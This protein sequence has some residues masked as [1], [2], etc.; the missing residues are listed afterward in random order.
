MTSTNSTFYRVNI[1]T[2]YKTYFDD[3]MVTLLAITFHGKKVIHKIKSIQNKLQR[4]Q[5]YKHVRLIKKIKNQ[6]HEL[7]YGIVQKHYIYNFSTLQY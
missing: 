4:F 5:C 1:F 2:V 6:F 7:S 3:V